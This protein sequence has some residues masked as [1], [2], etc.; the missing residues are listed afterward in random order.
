MAMKCLSLQKQNLI[1]V[2]YSEV[3]TL[4]PSYM[5]DVWSQNGAISVE[6]NS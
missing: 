5:G 2:Y 6:W 1:L 4:C 3:Y